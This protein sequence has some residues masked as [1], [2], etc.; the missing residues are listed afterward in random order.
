MPLFQLLRRDCDSW[1]SI[2]DKREVLKR[3]NCCFCC[4]KKG[5]R[6][7]DCRTARWLKC[8]SCFGKHL[9]TF[10]DPSMSS[11]DNTTKETAALGTLTEPKEV[12][13]SSL[14]SRDRVSQ[15]FLQTA[16][17]WAEVQHRRT[18]VRL[19]LD[20]GSQHTLIRSDLS[21]NLQ[22]WV[23]G[24]EDLKIYTFGGTEATKPTKSRGVEL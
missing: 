22:F 6:S 24:E 1:I 8:A 3:E 9:T 17:P 4:T 10:C 23:L 5:H 15:V 7:K 2:S 16:R 18:M 13:Q 19:L 11:N 20:V 21:N 12:L 14:G